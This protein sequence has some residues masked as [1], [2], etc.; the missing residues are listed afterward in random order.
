MAAIV[1]DT[2]SA[3]LAHGYGLACYCRQC[4]RWAL[5]NLGRQVLT[6]RGDRSFIRQQP[7]CRDCGRIG[8]WQLRAPVPQA[9][10]E[11]VR[12]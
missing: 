1:L 12:P 9:G 4:R 2:Y 7:R 6:G 11:S 3:L 10:F 8:E 5:V